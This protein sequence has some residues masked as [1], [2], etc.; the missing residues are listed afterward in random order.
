MNTALP[1][2][3]LPSDQQ[4]ESRNLPTRYVRVPKG[5]LIH[6][7]YHPLPVGVYG[8]IARLFLVLQAPVP[9][10]AADITRYDPSLSRGAAQR[11]LSRLVDDGWLIMTGAI[12]QKSSYVPTWGCV[13]GIP[14]AWRIG[15]PCLNR[16]RHVRAVCLDLR[17]LDI[18]LGKI[19]PHPTHAAIITRYITAPLLTLLDVG[20]YALL[21]GG[22][23]RTTP[24]LAMWGLVR[25]D[26]PL[27]LPGDEHILAHASQHTLF[28]HNGAT[29]TP[30][31]LRRIGLQVPSHT[32][33]TTQTLFFVPQG[34]IVPLP[35]PVPTAVIDQEPAGTP[36]ISGF[37]SH[38]PAST[39]ACSGITWESS[40]TP[41]KQEDSPPVPPTQALGGGRSVQGEKYTMRGSPCSKTEATQRLHDS[42]GTE[43]AR[44]LA[45]I[46]VLPDQVI[47]LSDISL[48]VVQAAIC[49]GR[50]RPYVR[51]L[52][53]WVVSLLRAHRDHGRAIAP[54]RA[55]PESPDA[56][57]EAFARYQGEQ[58]AH[59]PTDVSDALPSLSATSVPPD[60]PMTVSALWVAVL[61]TLKL[62][63]TRQE[64]N[65]YLQSAVLQ[66]IGDGQVTIAAPNTLVKEAIESR[67]FALLRDTIAQYV[68]ESLSVRVVLQGRQRTV[69][70]T[71][72]WLDESAGKRNLVS[73]VSPESHLDE[74]PDWIGVERWETL[75]TLLRAMLR[76][77]T[78]IDGQVQ[79]A[80]PY[81]DQVLYQRYGHAIAALADNE[82]DFAIRPHC[83]RAV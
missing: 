81:L 34:V 13:K 35:T 83:D 80:S 56:L 53:G 26:Q 11:A 57:R 18:F 36:R 54:P 78:L 32:S 61:A 37:Q 82:G 40:G 7:V 17:L 73:A 48:A 22:F 76:G 45:A 21:L 63:L 4:C 70:A 74:R 69:G 42:Q 33:S 27:P 79:A 75:P 59:Q 1:A 29:L 8:L 64:F 5:L 47:E 62:Q 68:G 19:T 43:A 77:A 66:A 46:Q 65:R 23:P 3:P 55:H 25:G 49:D 28:D 12:G 71:S 16:P 41:G 44:M 20:S 52:A 30:R 2:R 9:L 10:S 39:D 6:A 15:T 58:E 38:N 24:N 14:L 67:Y 50:S 72:P 31:G 51:D 60:P